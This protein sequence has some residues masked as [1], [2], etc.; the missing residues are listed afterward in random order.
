MPEAQKT[1]INFLAGIGLGSIDHLEPKPKL[2][3]DASILV[4]GNYYKFF[5]QGNEGWINRRFERILSFR[6][7]G[8]KFS[9]YTKTEILNDG[10]EKLSTEG[11]H[12]AVFAEPAATLRFGFEY[13]KLSSQVGFSFPISGRRSFDN[14]GLWLAMGLHL[15]FPKP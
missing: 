1:R 14:N 2:F 10:A 12:Y 7:T 4:E 6:I 5:V 3:P 9:N 13:F 8:I 11:R 15:S